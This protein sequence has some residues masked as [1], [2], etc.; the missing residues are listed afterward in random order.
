MIKHNRRH[1]AVQTP[2]LAWPALP[3]L[4]KYPDSAGRSVPALWLAGNEPVH[5]RRPCISISISTCGARINP[6]FSGIYVRSRHHASSHLAPPS[7][8][9]R[10]TRALGITKP[11]SRRSCACAPELPTRTACTGVAL[12]VVICGGASALAVHARSHS[13]LVVRVFAHLIGCSL[14]VK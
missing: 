13:T 8:P 14:A 7:G 9:P 4:S 6:A 11:L 10:E 5:Y 1:H 2:P 3:C 12:A